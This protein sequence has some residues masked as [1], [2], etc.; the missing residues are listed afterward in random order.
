MLSKVSKE[1]MR[2]QREQVE[3][4]ISDTGSICPSESNE[5][6]DTILQGEEVDLDSLK[7]QRSP[8]SAQ[9]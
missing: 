2:R 8:R 4:D 5:S 7:T 3:D 6:L 1:E 9:R